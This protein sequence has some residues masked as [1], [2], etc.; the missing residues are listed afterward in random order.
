MDAPVRLFSLCGTASRMSRFISCITRQ[1][2]TLLQPY[3]CTSSHF[4][5]AFDPC[6]PLSFPGRQVH[7]RDIHQRRTG[8]TPSP[9]H[10]SDQ[11]H[12]QLVIPVVSKRLYCFHL[13]VLPPIN[14]DSVNK[15]RHPT[16]SLYAHIQQ[17][18]PL[19]RVRCR[20]RCLGQRPQAVR[21]AVSSHRF[22]L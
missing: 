20:S 3:A 11:S 1:L 18:R 6:S 8:A 14:K 22:L 12:S 15:R 16:M 7:Q 21:S 10:L 5:C 4:P 13:F 17:I 2:H 19:R 9:L